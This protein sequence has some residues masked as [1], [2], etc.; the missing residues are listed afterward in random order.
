M[1]PQLPKLV[2]I[3]GPTASGKTDLA[4]RLAKKFNGEIISADSRQVFKKMDIGT[5]KPAGQW[6][7]VDEREVYMVEEV[8]HYG[9]DIVDPGHEMSMADFKKLALE[10]IRDITARGKVP[11]LVGGTGLYIWAVV[12]N[13]DM[14]HIPP[15][16]KLRRSLE[17]KPL[18]VLRT[19]LTTLDPKAAE[20]VDV[21]NPRR[22]VRALEVAILSG[23]SFVHQRRKSNPL[24]EALQV[25]IHWEK[26]ELAERLERRVDEQIA[27][28]LVAETE[29][30]IRQHY[31]WQ[32]PSM[33]SI[34]YKQIGSFL[35]GECTLAEAIAMIKA[36]TRQYAKRQ[37]TWFK[38]D[39]RIEWIER[40]DASAAEKLIKDFLGGVI[41]RSEAT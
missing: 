30:L 37:N 12:D 15:N 25:G 5:A 32:L 33:S 24:V 10:A 9:L 2:V 36:Q 34:G 40:D 39:N 35:R 26:D 16:K 18:D 29:N 38:R 17:E 1:P 41:T 3:L 20:F 23:E 11:F 6:Q 8:P 19:L 22:V 27:R 28:G 13:L 7:K 4:I 21:N 31:G 14:P